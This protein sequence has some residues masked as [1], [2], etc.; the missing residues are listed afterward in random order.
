[1]AKTVARIAL[2]EAIAGVIAAHNKDLGDSL[3]FLLFTM[4]TPDERTWRTLPRLMAVA[5]VRCP[6]DMKSYDVVFRGY[7]GTRRLTV[8]A[9]MA[10]KDR[11]IVSFCRDVP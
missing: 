9:P 2:K 1:M 5:R 11:T 7:R 4:E 8:S 10:R 6:A 3:R